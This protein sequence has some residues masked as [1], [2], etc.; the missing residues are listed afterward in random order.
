[1][2]IFSRLQIGYKKDAKKI[3][4]KIRRIKKM[5]TFAPF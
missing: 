2:L 5:L 4:K 1:M 3:K